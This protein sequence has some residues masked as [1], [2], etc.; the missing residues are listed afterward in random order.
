MTLQEL[1]PFEELSNSGKW[2]RNNPEYNKEYRRRNKEYF[3]EYIR[4]NRKSIKDRRRE[5]RRKNKIL[6]FEYYSNG[7]M[8]CARCGEKNID[9]LTIDHI[10][11]G[12][13]L[14]YR[15]TSTGITEW[16]SVQYRKTGRWPGGFQVLCANCNSIKGFEDNGYTSRHPISKLREEICL[17]LGGKCAICGFDDERA[18]HVEHANG[19]GSKEL[20][21]FSSRYAYFK[22]IREKIKA[23]SKEYQ[24]LCA[25]HNLEKEL[26][27]TEVRNFE[28]N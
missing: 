7:T 10:N 3:K 11:G 19:G 1:K 26:R 15:E 22:N 9:F 5:F 20:R 12:G 17:L 14:H 28:Y 25:N 8:A 18:L 4:N 2:N 21:S 24:L 23:G 6:A 16:L 13:A 27:E